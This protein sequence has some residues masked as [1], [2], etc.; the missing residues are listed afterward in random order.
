MRRKLS[1]L[2]KQIAS[3]DIYKNIKKVITLNGLNSYAPASL[4]FYMLFSSIPCLILV[5]VFLSIIN[6][7][8]GQNFSF[9]S[10]FFTNDPKISSSI[11]DI[12]SSINAGGYISLGISFSVIIYLASKGLTFFTIQNQKMNGLILENKGLVKRKIISIFT[13]IFLLL[14][15]SLF[16]VFLI[17]FDNI[18]SNFPT[19]LTFI[20]NYFFAMVLIFFLIVF[21]YYF[22]SKI[23]TKK[24]HFLGAF[25]ST[26]GICI[27]ILLYY[28]YLVNISKS[29]S[30]YGPLS[31]LSLLC[32]VFF[33][34]SYILFMGVQIN[35][36]NY[37]KAQ[38]NR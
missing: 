26:L 32:L 10:Y 4:S 2:I 35:I 8:L 38:K 34:S 7:T 5:E 14:V 12:I 33:Y 15:F 18:L 29:L 37:K 3:S 13:T 28:L 36:I 23:G 25:F 9:L 16:A 1:I 17:I 24:D 27:G 22:T 21:L 30:Y 19:V 6:N 31:S 20:I 11:K